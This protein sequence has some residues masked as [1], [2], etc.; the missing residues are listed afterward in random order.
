MRLAVT[1]SGFYHADIYC[2]DSR[3]AKQTLKEQ[4]V[5]ILAIEFYLTGRENGCDVLEWAVKQHLLPCFIVVIERDRSKRAVLSEKLF[6]AGYQ[7]ADN[8]TFVKI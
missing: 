8:T 6:S 7:S 3:S 2:V 5:S 1:R 4:P